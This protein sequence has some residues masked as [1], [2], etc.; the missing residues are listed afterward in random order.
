M[1]L[2]YG[3]KTPFATTCRRPPGTA[4]HHHAVV[5]TPLDPEDHDDDYERHH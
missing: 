3:L 1:P 5:G 4:K 2:P